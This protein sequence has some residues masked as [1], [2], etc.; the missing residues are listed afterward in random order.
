MLPF[1]ND[2]PIQ[3]HCNMP[4]KQ[5]ITAANSVALL[6]EKQSNSSPSRQ[7]GNRDTHSTAKVDLMDQ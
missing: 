5:L 4:P 7:N 3:S 2:K 6:V 1:S